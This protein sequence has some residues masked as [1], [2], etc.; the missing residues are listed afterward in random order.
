MT[1]AVVLQSRS[2]T[3]ESVYVRVFASLYVFVCVCV[4]TCE[5]SFYVCIL[6]SACSVH[7]WVFVRCSDLSVAVKGFLQSVMEETL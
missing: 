2:M 5:C 4:S 3:L 1:A 6:E 7:A